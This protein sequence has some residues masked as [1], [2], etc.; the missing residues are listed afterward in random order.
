M[1]ARL[2]VLALALVLA[3]CEAGVTPGASCTRASDC[4][5]GLVCSRGRCREACTRSDDCPALARCLVDP[6][7]ATR[8][9]SLD[10]DSCRTHAC[11]VGFLCRDDACLNACGTIVQCPDGVCSEGACVPTRGN[12]AG[13]SDAGDDHDG[14]T[15]AVLAIGAGEFHVCVVTAM[16]ELWCWGW[17]ADTQLGDGLVAHGDCLDCSPLAVRVT[18]GAT[19]LSDVRDVTGGA[20]YTCAVV[21][22]HVSCWGV[23]PLATKSVSHTPITVQ[24]SA[25]GTRAPLTGV[26]RV[27]GGL[28]HACAIVEGAQSGV[29]CWGT[30]D[31]GQLGTGDAVSS[32]DAVRA[33]EL[34]G[35]PLALAV[36]Y[37]HTMALA[38]DGS[39]LG[40][41]NNSTRALAVDPLTNATAAARSTTVPSA[42]RLATNAGNSC[43]IVPGGRLACWGFCNALETD[44]SPTTTVTGVSGL[45]SSQ[46]TFFT[47]PTSEPIAG[48]VVVAALP[49]TGACAWTETTG[50]VYCV[51]DAP[52]ASST[53]V[54]T[55]MNGLTGVIDMVST[56]S[57]L[58]ALTG[59][60]EV[61]CWGDDIHGQLGRGTH[62]DGLSP[63][64]MRVVIGP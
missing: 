24:T 9:C 4:P 55:Q 60:G 6:S 19:P 49:A 53:A 11:P 1:T 10:V 45:C 18:D 36:S 21:G 52:F 2:F 29:W 46:P 40:V 30:G 15:P 59:A 64:P 61:Y 58:C 13:A 56:D 38:S 3:A 41:G 37:H 35:D 22:D 7:T 5:A 28:L 8:T 39:I 57:A 12:D 34:P 62:D 48:I 23:A 42:T 27:E 50:E 43:A 44:T 26:R 33:T 16:R 25:S 17:S 32:I 47:L 14:G 51:G 63:T 54:P 31:D 20:E